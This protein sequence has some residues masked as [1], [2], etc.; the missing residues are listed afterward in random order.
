MDNDYSSFVETDDKPYHQDGGSI[1]IKLTGYRKIKWR[2]KIDRIPEWLD[3]TQPCPYAIA[4]NDKKRFSMNDMNVSLGK[5]YKYAQVA[6]RYKCDTS[7][8][9]EKT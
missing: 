8:Y 5:Y 3:Y 4:H 2:A 6:R 9:R 7:H 1:R